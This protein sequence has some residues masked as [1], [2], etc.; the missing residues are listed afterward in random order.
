MTPKQEPTN[1]VAIRRMLAFTFI[2]EPLMGR[3]W[4]IQNPTTTM[5]ILRFQIIIIPS[6]I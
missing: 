5:E 4:Q 3:N 2:A 1:F 6:V